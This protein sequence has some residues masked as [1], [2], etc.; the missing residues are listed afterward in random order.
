MVSICLGLQF[1]TATSS[2]CCPALHVRYKRGERGSQRALPG[3]DILSPS[4]SLS[5]HFS[6]TSS[7][8]CV[9]HSLSLSLSRCFNLL[10]MVLCVVCARRRD[11]HQLFCPPLNPSVSRT[12]QWQIMYYPAVAVDDVAYVDVRVCD[13]QIQYGNM[14]SGLDSGFHIDGLYVVLRCG[15]EV[16]RTSCLWPSSGTSLSSKDQLIGAVTDCEDDE[17]DWVWNE[18]F[19][20]P[21]LAPDEQADDTAPLPSRQGGHLLGDTARNQPGGGLSSTPALTPPLTT[22]PAMHDSERAS[23][24]V[25]PMSTATAAM[26]SGAAVAGL[27]QSACTYSQSASAAT[28]S[29]SLTGFHATTAKRSP[30]AKAS[31]RSPFLHPAIEL[32]LWRSTPS[33]ESCLSRYTYH[34]PLELLHGGYGLHQ[35]DVVA[36]RV[37]PLRTKEASSIMG[38]LYGWSGHRLSLRLRVQA[39]GLLPI[40]A[41]WALPAETVNASVAGYSLPYSLSMAEQAG[42]SAVCNTAYGSAMGSINPVLA[43]LLA[44]LGVPAMSGSGPGVRPVSGVMGGMNGNTNSCLPPVFPLFASPSVGAVLPGSSSSSAAPA[45]GGQGVLGDGE[46]TVR[47]PVL[48]AVFPQHPTAAPPPRA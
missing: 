14:P 17:N 5:P 48:P 6:P 34:V 10:G 16:R 37:V 8:S 39:V 7:M 46:P 24:A 43:N 38:N 20:F 35:L 32:E 47:G 31:A 30:G 4:P 27:S 28:P 36:E 2:A 22:S 19:R 9:D 45:F 3:N 13:L 40:T 18:L 23:N 42:R 15:N 12:F 41:D 26:A 44:P 25:L 33:A 11:D 21:L 1:T 29:P